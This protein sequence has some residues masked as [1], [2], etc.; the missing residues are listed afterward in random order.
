MGMEFAQKR[1]ESHYSLELKQETVEKVL[2]EGRSKK[3][4][5]LDY[6]SNQGMFP[7]WLAHTGKTVY[8]SE[9]TRGDQLNGT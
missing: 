4:E 6:A 2:L 1:E 9:K 8:H 7:N 5:V 3:C